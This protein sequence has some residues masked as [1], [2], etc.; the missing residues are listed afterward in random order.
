MRLQLAYGRTGLA[1]ELPDDVPLTVIEPRF[2][3]GL[4]DERLE[5]K[6]ALRSPRGTAPLRELVA[7]DDMVAVV[8]SDLTRPMPNERVLPPLLEELDLAGVSREQ[9]VLIN[10]LEPTGRRPKRS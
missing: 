10:G 8:F 5:V 2:V 6:K 4:A 1:I 3:P 9:V 7:P